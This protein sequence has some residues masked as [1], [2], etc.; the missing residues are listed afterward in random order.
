MFGVTNPKRAMAA[1][2]ANASVVTRNPIAT[3]GPQAEPD[4]RSAG[5]D[6]SSPGVITATRRP[7]RGWYSRCGATNMAR[8]RATAHRPDL[9]FSFPSFPH[10]RTVATL[11]SAYRQRRREILRFDGWRKFLSG[12]PSGD[13]SGVVH[14]ERCGVRHDHHLAAILDKAEEVDGVNDVGDNAK[15]GKANHG[16][17][18]SYGQRPGR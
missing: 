5:A 11:L 17:A 2:M 15:D 8:E 12:R 1:V 13:G 18:E 6:S 3:T 14:R 4:R 7:E 16:E 10:Q 9:G